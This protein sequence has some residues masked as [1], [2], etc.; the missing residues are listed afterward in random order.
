DPGELARTDPAELARALK[1]ARPF[2]QFRHD[3]MLQAGDLL[4]PEGRAPAAAAALTAVAEHP[5]DL[6]RDQYVMRLADLCQIDTAKLRE[7]LEPLRAH[8]PAEKPTRR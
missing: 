8:P 2:L 6:V 1:E 7:R 4:A 3:R 5:D